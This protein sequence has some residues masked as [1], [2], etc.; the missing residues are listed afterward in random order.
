[1][2]KYPKKSQRKLQNGEGGTGFGFQTFRSRACT[3]R[4][5]SGVSELQKKIA[6]YTK[7]KESNNQ[8]LDLINLLS[9]Q[10]V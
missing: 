6:K 7:T 2:S 3:E 8:Q 5:V 1:M 4:W 9:R 10:H